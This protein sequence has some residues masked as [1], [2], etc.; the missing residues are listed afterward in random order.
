MFATSVLH[1]MSSCSECF[2]SVD[3]YPF[4]TSFLQTSQVR[5]K[6][7]ARSHTEFGCSRLLVRSALGLN[8]PMH[9]RIRFSSKPKRNVLPI[10][11]SIVVATQKALHRFEIWTDMMMRYFAKFVLLHEWVHAYMQ[12][13]NAYNAN[14]TQ[15]T[16]TYTRT[17]K[18]A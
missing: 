2:E 5:E 14:K 4:E 11:W 12:T 7:P 3:R 16:Q 1:C 9:P 6:M 18:H 15:H 8:L 17:R 10:L 13:Y